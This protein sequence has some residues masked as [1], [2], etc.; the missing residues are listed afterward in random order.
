MGEPKT[1]EAKVL[2]LLPNGAVKL[3][4]ESRAQVIGHPAGATKVN[5]TRLRPN[6]RVLVELSPH[7]ESRGRIVKLLAGSA[8][9]KI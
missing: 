2:D 1:V 7:D 5:F 3:E 6:D 9:G 8:G 4:L